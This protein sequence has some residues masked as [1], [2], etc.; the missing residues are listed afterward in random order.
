MVTL[1]DLEPRNG[2]HFAFLR[3]FTDSGSFEANSVELT[4]AR[5]TVSATVCSRKIVVF[6]V[7]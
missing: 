5:P 3:H 2:R 1:N 6:G 4:E 7:I